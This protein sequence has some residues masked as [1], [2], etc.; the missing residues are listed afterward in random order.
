MPQL[1]IAAACAGSIT[2]FVLTPVELIKCRMQVQ[3]ISAE[4]AAGGVGAIAAGAGAGAGASSKAAFA[5]LP[6][7]VALVQQTLRKEGLRGLWLGQTGTLLR[8]T[9]GGVAWF[10]A[11]E[12]VSR[13]FCE[14]RKAA[15]RPS[16]KKDLSSLELVAA[17]ACSGVGYNVA[18]FPVSWFAHQLEGFFSSRSCSL[19]GRLSQV[20][21]ADRGRDGCAA[22]AWRS[23]AP[24]NRLWANL[25]AH[26]SNAWLGWLVCWLRCH[27]SA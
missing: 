4:A 23:S 5:N 10:L 26:L 7:P 24:A 25:L 16:T 9:G 18:L 14:R 11:F 19:T 22:Q 13:W 1:G 15:G 6:G 20:N 17:G 3:L 2:S 8:E 21:D 12:G 27:M